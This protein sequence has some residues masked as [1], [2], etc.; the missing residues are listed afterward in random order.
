MSARP[1]AGCERFGGFN[2][3]GATGARALLVLSLMSAGCGYQLAQTGT[4][5]RA[6]RAV[7][8]GAVANRTAQAE[9]GGLF[10]A[11]LR[12]ELSARGEL[13]G[14]AAGAPLLETE[15]AALRNAPSAFGAATAPAFRVEAELRFK[16]RENTGAITYEDAAAGGEDY[17]VGIDVLGTEANRRA[18]LRRLAAAMAR[19]AVER[20]EMAARF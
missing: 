14:E 19:E 15:L 2:F 16:L 18:A 4:L 13:A 5:P 1:A 9:A 11:A 20:M 10:G 17:L 12:D 6:A 8:V 7:R 3:R